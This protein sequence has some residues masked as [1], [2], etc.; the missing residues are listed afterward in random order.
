MSVLELKIPP[1]VVFA[2]CALLEWL[3]SLVLPEAPGADSLIRTLIASVLLFTGLALIIAAILTF[4]SSQ[5]S[6]N[7][8]SP[9]KASSIVTTGAY[10]LSRN[11]MYLAM[12]LILTALGFYLWQAVNILVLAAFV[13]Y[14]TRFQIIP[15][16]HILTSKFDSEF[17]TYLD[18]V[19]RWI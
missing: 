18:E 11:P 8:N 17:K 9:D 7:P 19:R 5:T 2:I 12:F 13:A 4:R 6:V 14:I 1:I 3:S 10:T 16:E 15:E